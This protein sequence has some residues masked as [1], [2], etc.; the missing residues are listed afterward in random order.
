MTEDER[1]EWLAGLRP[2]GRVAF[3][4]AIGT[5]CGCTLGERRGYP[6]P[7]R[8][9]WGVLEDPIEPC[10]EQEW[11]TKFESGDLFPLPYPGTVGLFRSD[12]PRPA[13]R[14]SRKKTPTT[15]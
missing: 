9:W 13:R 14:R 2:G 8:G 11:S 15:A 3:W 5:L 10:G 12:P 4:W 1:R 6:E 7:G